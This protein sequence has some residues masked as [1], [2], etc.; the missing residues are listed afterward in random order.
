ML[1]L[2]K[3]HIAIATILLCTVLLHRSFYKR[4]LVSPNATFTSESSLGRVVQNAMSGAKGR[5]GIFIKNFKTEEEYFVNEHQAFEPGS[6][7][8][9]WVMA[10]TFQKIKDGN[11]KEDEILGEDIPTLNNL[12]NIDPEDAEQQDGRIELTVSS[13]LNQMITISH[14]YAALLLTEKIGNSSI[15]KF[16]VE[17]GFKESKIGQPPDTTVSD[18]ATFFDK[19]YKGEIIGIDY[20]QKMLELLKRQQLNDGLPN[21]LPDQTAVAHKTGDIGWFKHDG[22]IIYS[23]KGDYLVVVM[24]ESDF[25]EGA[26]ERIALLSKAVWDY[27]NKAK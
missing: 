11:L 19:L 5:Y 18:I 7:Y 3:K 12:F 25:P 2:N 17:N 8:K 22:G 15:T 26:Q 20:S 24:S 21:Y 14:N 16:L 10:T 13:A 9:L 6:L 27:F 1:R 4:P 23:P